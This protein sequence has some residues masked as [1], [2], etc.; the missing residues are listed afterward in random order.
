MLVSIM[1]TRMLLSLKR[2]CAEDIRQGWVLEGDT[3]ETRD[4][5]RTPRIIHGSPR[6]SHVSKPQI[7]DTIP[8]PMEVIHTKDERCHV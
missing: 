1:T 7:G 8:I 3:D 4:V 5:P 6:F 2:A